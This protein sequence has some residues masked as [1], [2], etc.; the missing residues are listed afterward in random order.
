MFKG[1]PEKPINPMFRTSNM[2]YG[3]KRPNIHT[4]PTNFFPNT[5]GFTEVIILFKKYQKKASNV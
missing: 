1:Y 5:S 3:L 4:M 2:D